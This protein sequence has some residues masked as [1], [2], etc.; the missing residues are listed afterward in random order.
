M[1][2]WPAVTIY[3]DGACD[4]N[5]GPGGW[6]AL[7]RFGSHEK[8]LKGSVAQTTNNRMELQAVIAALGALNQPCRVQLCTDSQYVQRGIT[9]HLARWKDRDW[10]TSGGQSVA[11]RDLWEALDQAIQRHQIEWQ[12]VK[13]HAD[14]PLNERVDRLAASTIPRS[15]LPRED[16]AATHIF[17]GVSCRGASG[18]G[19]WAVVICTTAGMQTLSGREVHTSANRLHLLALVQGLAAVPAG[20]R[21]H[22]YTPSDYAAQGA[23]QWVKKW[24]TQGWHTQG[25]QAVKH[26]EVWQ[27]I[28]AAAQ[29]RVVNWHCLKGEARPAES[30]QAEELAHQTALDP[31]AA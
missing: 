2:A 8:E 18:P 22:L 15:S 12:W 14:D 16:T 28:Q 23:Q 20:V 31:K 27:A 13:G 17:T 30:R 1:D 9:Q 24:A 21:V 6:A 7:L 3:T 10:K 26:A 4:P 29:T 11:N 19:A 25:G 5:P